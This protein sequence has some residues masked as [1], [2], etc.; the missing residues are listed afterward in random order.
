MRPAH[1]DPA[2][3][4][5]RREPHTIIIARGD[6]IRHFQLRA[7]SKAGI[8]ALGSA[9]LLGYMAATGYL[10]VR[11]DLMAGKAARQAHI[12]Y[13]YE[14]RI[15]AL[16]RQVDRITS[17]QM[18]DQNLVETRMAEL[19]ERQDTLANRSAK[20]AP[21]LREFGVTTGSVPMPK[22]RPDRQAS[23]IA[24]TMPLLAA[25][26]LR[27]PLSLADR[28]DIAFVA[29]QHSLKDME[30]QQ[31]REIDAVASKAETAATQLS[32]A[33]KKVGIASAGE[34]ETSGMG[35]PFEP[36]GEDSPVTFGAL[37]DRLDLALARYTSIRET[38]VAVPLANPLPGQS[39]SSKF[40]IRKDPI[41]GRRAMH[42]GLDFSARRGVPIASAADGVVIK[43]GRNGGYGKMVEIRHT[44]GL[45]T[46]YAHMSRISVKKGQAIR[47]GD[48]VG[49][50][51]STGRSTGPHLHYEV[52]RHGEAL[53]P[54][55]FIRAGEAVENLL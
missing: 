24:P 11:D 33:L 50:V 9:L 1:L 21:L 45:V 41:V 30:S 7:W 19:M 38:A 5:G 25:T 43:A 47:R 20:I 42:S 18:L 53:D 39:I 28:A 6:N 14:D 40:G 32:E 16:R 10:V 2:R 34:D 23:A 17:R 49:S 31:I 35:G 51:G 36:V 44:D 37:I 12:E 22:A 29:L 13:A 27:A 46:R 15:S 4:F 8:V 54:L 55:R 48:T 3:P 52:R 26:E